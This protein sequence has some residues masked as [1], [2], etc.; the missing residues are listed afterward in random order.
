MFICL[1]KNRK[2]LYKRSLKP[3]FLK[4]SYLFINILPFPNSYITNTCDNVTHTR[5][6]GK[7]TL[8]LSILNSH[9]VFRD[10]QSN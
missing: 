9:R 4:H 2:Q 5:T 10:F 3:H 6:F 8:S 7:I 1:S